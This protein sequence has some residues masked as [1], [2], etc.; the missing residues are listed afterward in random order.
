MIYFADISEYQSTF[1]AGAYRRAGNEVIICRTHN[2]ARPDHMMPGRMAQVRDVPF[3]AVGYYLYLLQSRDPA[4][5][6]R[7]FA[8][9]IG[10]LRPNEFPILDHEEGA[11]VQTSRAEAALRVLDGWAGFPA[12]L[13]ASSSFFDDKLSG[14]ERWH[15][16]KWFAAYPSS[17]SANMSLYP[18]TATFWQYSDRGHFTGLPGAVDANCCPQTAQQ[19][20]AAV[21]SGKTADTAPAPTPARIVDRVEVRHQPDGDPELFALDDDECVWHRWRKDGKWQSWASLGKP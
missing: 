12:T 8:N 2:G 5:Q 17:Y 14:R 10:Q 3:V 13:Y 6:A 21:R 15:R 7:A 19:L 16:P 4:E 11:G 20:L 18:R 9:G 1:D